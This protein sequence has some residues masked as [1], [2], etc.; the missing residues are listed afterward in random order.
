MKPSKVKGGKINGTEQA[1]IK[2]K[3]NEKNNRNK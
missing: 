3:K 2:V 1:A